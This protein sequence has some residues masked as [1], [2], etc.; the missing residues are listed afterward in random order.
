MLAR[1]QHMYN[2]RTHS[3]GGEKWLTPLARRAESQRW[4]SDVRWAAL[5]S[6]GCERGASAEDAP[7]QPCIGC[8]RLLRDAGENGLLAARL[9]AERRQYRDAGSNPAGRQT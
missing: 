8:G 5:G 6:C 4:R 7:R 3:I 1:E 9:R 2:R